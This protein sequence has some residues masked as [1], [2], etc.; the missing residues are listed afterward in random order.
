[1][2]GAYSVVTCRPSQRTSAGWG[3]L[4]CPLELQSRPYGQVPQLCVVHP[5]QTEPQTRPCAEQLVVAAQQRL[6][7]HDW[8]VGQFP[9]NSVQPSY[10]V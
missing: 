1:M 3:G 8:P 5:V 10:V 9:Q 7:E 6:Y 4:H 2:V